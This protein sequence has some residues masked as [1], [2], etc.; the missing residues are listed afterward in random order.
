MAEVI[1]KTVIHELLDRWQSWLFTRRFY[2]PPLPKNILDLMQNNTKVS[3]GEPNGRND[4]LCAAFNLVMTNAPDHERLP[5]VYVYLKEYRPSPIKTLA[6][7]MGIDRDTVYQRAHESAIKFYNKA[8]ELEKL[9]GQL[10]KEIDDY[11]D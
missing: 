8:K 9:H 4:A 11:V 7:E 10:Q 1:N 3:K 2:A 5:F 6:H